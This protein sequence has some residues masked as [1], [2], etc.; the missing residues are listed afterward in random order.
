MA[1]RLT[2]AVLLLALIN[3][4]APSRAVRLDT[5]QGAPMEYRPP[6][7][8]K[9]VKVDADA[10]EKALRQLA[11]NAPLTL[12]PAQQGGFVRAS[13]P[14][15][16]ADTRWQRLMSKR[17]GGLCKPEQRREDCLSLLDD[18]MGLSQWDKLGWAWPCRSIPSK[19][20]SPRR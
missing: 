8:S 16:D 17:F 2:V 4:C 6:T 3:A 5:G 15:L 19:R 14:E 9:P 12:R 18:V 11:L 20:A 13:Y 1:T 10:F 7:S